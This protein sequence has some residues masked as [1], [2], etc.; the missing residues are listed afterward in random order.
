MKMRIHIVE[1]QN[2]IECGICKAQ[3]DWIKKINIR[4]IP[5]LYCLKCDTLTMF[6]KMPSKYVY[7]A[8]K[9]ETDNLKMEYSVKQNEKVK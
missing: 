1:P 3:G 8:F 4:G 5:A 7:R 6:D 2:K 9:K